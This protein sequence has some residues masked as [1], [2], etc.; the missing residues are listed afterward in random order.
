MNRFIKKLSITSLL[1]VVSLFISSYTF[2]KY[3]LSLTDIQYNKTNKSLEIITNVFMDDIELELNKK[4]N[5]NLQLTSPQQYKKTDSL[6]QNYFKEKLKFTIDQEPK[7]FNYIGIEFEGDLVFIY[8]EINNVTNP[9]Q[10]EIS[11]TILLQN[12][13]DQK[14]IVKVKL[15]N[16]RKSDILNKKNIK[17]VLNY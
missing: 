1:V 4:Y 6:F 8:M 11:N 15:N 9:K 10:F 17:T 12:F 5:V 7:A 14:N 16:K 13:E 3:Y 2:H